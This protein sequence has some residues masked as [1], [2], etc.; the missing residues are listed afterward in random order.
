MTSIGIDPGHGD[1][2][3]G[4][5]CGDSGGVLVERETVERAAELLRD[6]L[7]DRGMSA[8]L[9]RRVGSDPW[10]V[11]RG[12]LT[13]G[14]A[15]VVSLH[16][17]AS[18]N[19]AANGM[20]L[21]HWPQSTSGRALAVEIAACCPP[22]LRPAGRIEGCR[23]IEASDDP[24]T[25][26]DDWKQRPRAVLR[27]HAPPAVLVELGYAS[28]PGNR[29]YLLSEVGLLSAVTAVTD[30]VAEWVRRSGRMADATAG[31]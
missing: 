10:F 20:E 12:A 14:C 29:A 4:A 26:A 28:H 19:P 25:T 13:R 18:R 6:R 7:L 15:A 31:R 16:V 3:L 27:W 17:N 1:K 23:I 5:V 24:S 2:D 8:L 9:T 22:A 21:Y 11:T 30:G